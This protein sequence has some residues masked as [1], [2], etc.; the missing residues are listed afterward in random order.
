MTAAAATGYSPAAA[1]GLAAGG[2]VLV[3][4]ALVGERRPLVVL[5]GLSPARLA[6]MLEDGQTDQAASPRAT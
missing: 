2:V 1:G 5:R 6:A 4:A 3:L